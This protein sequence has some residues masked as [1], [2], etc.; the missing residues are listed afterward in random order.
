[1]SFVPAIA[2]IP[3]VWN[4]PSPTYAGLGGL[5]AATDNPLA[6][7]LSLFQVNVAK[8]VG[9]V[10][11]SV[12]GISFAS[13]S[14]AIEWGTNMN[15]YAASVVQSLTKKTGDGRAFWVRYPDKAKKLLL[16]AQKFVETEAK[17]YKAA[18]KHLLSIKAN[19]K[20]ASTAVTKEV[21]DVAHEVVKGAVKGSPW[22]V[23]GVAL[24]AAIWI[25]GQVK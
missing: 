8:M 23:G 18:A 21:A 5:G 22:V 17:Q 7:S 24:L 19:L 4:K 3:P 11:R 2:P 15:H 13:K 14:A 25:Y 10:V 20:Q 16:D 6:T 12:S 9:D 1:M